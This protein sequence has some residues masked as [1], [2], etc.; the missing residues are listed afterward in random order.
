MAVQGT[1]K[2]VLEEITATYDD[3]FQAEKK[4]ADYILAN[5]E[6]AVNSNVSELANNSGVRDA[7][8]IRFCKHLGYEGYYQMRLLLSRDIGR[9][10]SALDSPD[11]AGTSVQS[12]FQHIADSALAAANA[13][14]EKVYRDA[15]ELLRQCTMVHLVAM[16][17]TTS[18]CQDMGPRL[19]RMGIRCTYSILAEHYMHHIHLGSSTDVVLAISGS[20]SSK[21]VVKA[22]NLAREKGMKSIAVTAFQYSPVSRLADYLLLSAPRGKSDTGLFRVSRLNEMMVLET[23]A[24]MLEN[25]VI[26]DDVDLVESEMFLSE[27]KL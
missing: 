6:A 11:N 24:I 14:D 25:S 1:E 3:L 13:T 23:L 9:R 4:V 20:G 10:A 21:N 2:T 7:T 26:S 15:V 16:G 8:V 18:L 17:N 19:E 27:T 12:I 22:L 5:H